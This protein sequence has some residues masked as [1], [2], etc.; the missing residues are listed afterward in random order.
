VRNAYI[1]VRKPEGSRPFGKCR[2]SWVDNINMIL[3]KL[4]VRMWTVYALVAGSCEHTD[5]LVG[6]RKGEE[7]H[8]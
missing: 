3:T 7:F 2:N 8:D 1:F 4:N 6:S 5:K